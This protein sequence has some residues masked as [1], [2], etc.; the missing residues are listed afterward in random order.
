MVKIDMNSLDARQ[1]QGLQY[2]V[3]KANVEVKTRNESVIAQNESIK[4]ANENKQEGE[5]LVSE[6][7]LEDE[8]T[9]EGY[10]TSRIEDVLESYATQ[11][12][13]ETLSTVHT[14]DS[15]MKAKIIAILNGNG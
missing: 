8:V 13:N 14:V 11:E 7:P 9:P 10:L 15:N 2:V 12:E 3:D 4:I 1:R 5:A 6:I